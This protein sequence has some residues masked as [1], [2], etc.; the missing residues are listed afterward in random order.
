MIYLIITTSINNKD[1]IENFNHR[2]K[3]YIEC[4]STL[5]NLIKIHQDIKPIIV[6]NNNYKKTYLNDIENICDIIYT[7]NNIINYK[8][9]GVN[10]LLDIK[11]VINRYNIDDNDMIIKLTGRYKLLNL[12]FIDI[13]KKY[14]DYDAFLKFFNVSTLKYHYNKDDCI[15]GLFAIKCKYL[16]KFQYKC[17]KSPECEFADFVKESITKIIEIKNLNLECC[18]AGD[19]RILYV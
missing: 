4:I 15:L 5:L 17:I 8:H 16:K 3:R 7:S 6:E 13:I 9:K 11:E 18:F 12:E 14:I 19:L 2:K 10:E 1:G